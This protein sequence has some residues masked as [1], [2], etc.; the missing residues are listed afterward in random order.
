M[1]ARAPAL[2]RA[3]ALTARARQARPVAADLLH[4]Q[5]LR[6]HGRVWLPGAPYSYPNLPYSTLPRPQ[7]RPTRVP[8]SLR[9][10]PPPLQPACASA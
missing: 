6:H 9:A 4:D 8:D 3:P 1:M 2:R 10:P 7:P 5:L